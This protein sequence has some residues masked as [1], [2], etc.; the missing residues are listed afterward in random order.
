MVLPHKELTKSCINNLHLGALS[1][2][3]SPFIALIII[4]HSLAFLWSVFI[5]EVLNVWPSRAKGKWSHGSLQISVKLEVAAPSLLFRE[6]ECLRKPASCSAHLTHFSS[7]KQQTVIGIPANCKQ[8]EFHLFFE[9]LFCS[10]KSDVWIAAGSDY[11]FIFIM[12]RKKLNRQRCTVY[13]EV[14]KSRTAEKLCY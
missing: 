8:L 10:P 2:N 9:M 7:F 14:Q 12:N 1:T 5:C 6:V 11:P 13:A 4:A 3:Q